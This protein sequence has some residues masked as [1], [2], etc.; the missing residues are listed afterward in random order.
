[1]IPRMASTGVIVSYDSKSILLNH[2]NEDSCIHLYSLS[3][4][5]FS[6]SRKRDFSKETPFLVEMIKDALI[7][8]CI[9][10]EAV[11]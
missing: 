2:N 5:V 8:L 6:N 11:G 10:N 4:T 9:Y 3:L 7:T 1:M